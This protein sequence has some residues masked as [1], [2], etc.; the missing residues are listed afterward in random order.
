MYIYCKN[1]INYA[2][3]LYSNLMDVTLKNFKEFFKVLQFG[4]FLW[5]LY[6]NSFLDAAVFPVRLCEFHLQY[7]VIPRT[8]LDRSDW[9]FLFT[10]FNAAMNHSS[11]VS[12]FK[13]CAEKY[14]AR[15]QTE[16]YRSDQATSDR[17]HLI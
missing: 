12:Q 6:N 7:T 11:C 10:L 5:S 17:C 1:H 13:S 16:H 15:R 8:R 2:R 4:N 14:V 3:D 9:P